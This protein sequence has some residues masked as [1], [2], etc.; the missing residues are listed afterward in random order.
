MSYRHVYVTSVLRIIDFE[1]RNCGE[2]YED[3]RKKRKEK[4]NNKIQLRRD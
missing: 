4:K 1:F 3:D 2:V